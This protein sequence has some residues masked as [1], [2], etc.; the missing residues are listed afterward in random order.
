M[1]FLAVT[2]WKVCQNLWGKIELLFVKLKF[3]PDHA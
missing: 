3:L 2:N 1:D